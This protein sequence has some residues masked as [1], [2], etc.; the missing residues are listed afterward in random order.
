MSVFERE[1]PG[2]R[3]AETRRGDTLQRVA[4]RELGDAERWYELAFINGLRP[5]YLTDDSESAATGVLLTGATLSVPATTDYVPSHLDPRAVFGTDVRLSNDGRLS[6]TAGEL[7]VISGAPNLSQAVRHVVLTDPGDLV[8][9]MT[10][11]CGV[12]RL[13]GQ[14][15][16]AVSQRLAAALVRRAVAA[17]DRVQSADILDLDVSGDAVRTTVRITAINGARV[18]ASL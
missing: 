11:G 9:H 7:D 8:W 12:R 16:D 18:E 17:D 10:Y 2:Y 4:A 5:P 3:L 15:S 13:L 14:R 1:Y 6:A